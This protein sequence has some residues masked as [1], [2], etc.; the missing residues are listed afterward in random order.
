MALLVYNWDNFWNY[1]LQIAPILIGVGAL[2]LSFYQINRSERLKK[3]ESKRD[4]IY[5]KLNNFYGPY[6]QLRR[7]SNILYKKFRNSYKESDPS[8]STLKYLLNGYEFK[9]N[10]KSILEEIIAI[11]EQSEKLIQDN[12]G[13][14]DDDE[15]RN[16]LI[17]KA[18]T[19]YLLLRMAYNGKILGD[20]ENFKDSTFPRQ[21]DAKLIERKNQLENDLN[22]LN[23]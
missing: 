20:I 11:G 14:I 7:K 18:S 16:D 15:L 5:K 8:F 3:D 9:D 17:P 21:I 19:H 23:N 6:Y 22:K 13:L 10:E 12:A 2:G 4:E 1:L